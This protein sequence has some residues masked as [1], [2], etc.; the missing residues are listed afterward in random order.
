ME[1]VDYLTR[2]PVLEAE[3]RTLPKGSSSSIASA[4]GCDA[5]HTYQYRHGLVSLSTPPHLALGSLLHE[6]LAHVLTVA[7]G[8]SPAAVT[9]P[10]A[11]PL[12]CHAAIRCGVER[13]SERTEYA[14]TDWDS[15][16]LQAL[17]SLMYHVPRMALE[18]WRTLFV[19]HDLG[20]VLT[21]ADGRRILLTGR[22]DWIVEHLPSGDLT[23]VDHKSSASEGLGPLFV[24]H[25]VQLV[26]YRELMRAHGLSPMRTL[27]HQ[28]SSSAPKQPKRNKDGSVSAAKV[29]SDWETVSAA[30][31]RAGGD[32]WSANYANLR[33]HCE[34]Q[35]FRRWAVDRTSDFAHAKIFGEVQRTLAR[36][37]A[38]EQPPITHNRRAWNCSRCFY[39]AWCDADLQGLDKSAL[40]GVLYHSDDPPSEWA[41]TP[42]N[43]LR[44]ESDR[45]ALL[46]AYA[47][48]WTP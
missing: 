5:A 12:V 14:A 15:L 21:T 28:I 23:L 17:A 32:P 25:D 8:T 27:H 20:V 13:L 37:T 6:G 34:R 33:E 4:L 9:H 31:Q 2:A 36:I 7:Q 43:A 22:I 41:E 18:K 48:E 16:G 44:V 46:G 24:E 10:S 42:G 3:W 45:T 35:T 19:E 39:R 30:I 40:L 38:D 1:V 26:I 29:R 11:L 47:E